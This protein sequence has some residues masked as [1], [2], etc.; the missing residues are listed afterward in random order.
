MY[1]ASDIK[2]CFQI[3]MF[4]LNKIKNTS[5]QHADINTIFP[6]VIVSIDNPLT[7]LK[8]SRYILRDISKYYKLFF[9]VYRRMPLLNQ[10]AKQSTTGVL[11]IL[12]VVTR[13][14]GPV[15]N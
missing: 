10:L 12:N 4:L 15:K 6:A 9:F 14:T 7:S 11:K 3:V 2:G 13:R 5:P 8:N 1:E